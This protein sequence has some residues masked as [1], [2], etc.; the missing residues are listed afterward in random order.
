MITTGIQGIL[1]QHQRDLG[2][3]LQE[4]DHCVSL[5]V[6]DKWVCGW[7]AKV[8]TFAQI[9]QAAYQREQELGSGV[10]YAS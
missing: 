2:M 1:T 9:Q 3:S 8:V 6:K 10:E 7:S 4:D 5:L